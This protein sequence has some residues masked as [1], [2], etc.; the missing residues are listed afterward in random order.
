MCHAI[1][2]RIIELDGESG[3]VDYGGVR[4][5]A[6]LSLVAGA[7]AGDYVL[8]HAGFAIERLDGRSAKETLRLMREMAKMGGRP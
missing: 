3:I 7:R 5:K 8:I 4:K 1:P 2:A 6:N